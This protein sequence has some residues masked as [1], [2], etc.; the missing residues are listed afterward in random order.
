MFGSITRFELNYQLR[1][2]AFIAIF[3]IFFLL[4]FFATVSD[5]VS[6]GASNTVNANS[7]F[8]ITQ[9]IQIMSLFAMIIPTACLATTLLRDED[10]KT[11]EMFHATPVK[12]L[13]FV[14]GRF[15]GGLLVTLLAFASVPLGALIGPVFGK[16]VGWLQP[17]DLGP[18]NIGH[19]VQIFL[20]MGVPNMFITG[21]ILFS[22]ANFTR[23]MIMVFAALLSIYTLYFAGNAILSNP[24]LR[25][26]IALVDPFALNTYGFATQYWTPAERNTIVAP[27]EGVLLYNRLIWI[28]VGLALLAANF[29]FF[30]FRKPKAIRRKAAGAAEAG[31]TVQ[32]IVLPRVAPS[33]GASAQM[34]QFRQRIRFEM[35]VVVKNL[36][37]WVLL[38]LGL[39]NA[40]SSLLFTNSLYGTPPYPVT[41][42][43]ID[44]LVGSFAFVPI[45]VAVYYA[46]ELVWR[47]RNVRMSDIVDATPTPSWV[48]VASKFIAL[49][50]VI[51]ALFGVAMITALLVQLIKGFTAVDIGQYILRLFADFALPFAILAALAIFFQVVFNNKWLGIMAMIVYTIVTLIAANYGFDHNLY[52]YGGSPTAPYSDMNGYGHYLG[53]SLWFN[54]YWGLIAAALI[55][56]CYLLWNRGAL[57]PIWRRFGQ[58]PARI[59]LA[60]GGILAASLVGAGVV[61]GYIFYNTN[62]LNTYRNQDANEDRAEAFELAYRDHEF[63]PIPRITAVESEVDIYPRQRRYTIDGK[64]TLINATDAPIERVMID[65][66]YT[67]DVEAQ[68]IEGATL[69]ESDDDYNVYWFEFDEPLAPGATT[70]MTFKTGRHDRGFRNS[71]NVS[72]INYNGTFFNNGEAFP[73]I[74]FNAGKLL[75]NPQERRKRGLEELPR[76]YKLEDERFFNVS[77]LR[78]DSLWVDFATTVSTSADQIA[79][80]PGYLEREWEENGRRYFRYVMDE[81][82]QN[83]YSFQ[84]GDYVVAEG[85][86]EDVQLQVFYHEDHEFNVDRMIEGMAD[87]LEYFS[88]HFSP[89]QYRQ[90]R[91]QEFP[92]YQSFAQSF[93]NTVPYSEGIGFI[94][95]VRDPDDI[96]FIYYVTAHEVAHQWWGHQV[97]PAPV[98]GAAMVTETLAQ[99]SA[100][101]VLEKEY[102]AEH[103]RRFLKF[104]LDSYLR[105]RAA[106]NR[107]EL[108]LF[109]EE[110]QGYIHYRK[111]SIAMWLLQDIIGEDKVNRALNRLADEFGY[112]SEPF[113]RSVDLI[114]V[115]REEAGP[116]H[117][118]L[119]TDLF[120]K[121]VLYDLRVED[122][123][124]NER[125]DGRW[126]VAM[127]VFARKLEADGQGEETEIALDNLPVDVGVFST[128]LENVNSGT[129]H[130]LAFE[131]RPLDASNFV[132]EFVVDERPSHA[133]VDPYNKVIDRITNDNL[134][135]VRY[136]A[137]L[138]DAEGGGEPLASAAP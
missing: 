44:A 138:N 31:D 126:D 123:V 72:T 102:G 118:A 71:G 16:A 53:I 90:M 91:I 26:F 88:E 25:E 41:R 12:P 85:Q 129:D 98:Q 20:V 116:E 45:V 9:I 92:A 47:E 95:D 3:A 49:S 23:S 130:I 63:D 99:Y 66:S 75:Q 108:P 86:W 82:I 51:V 1:G 27:L 48:F 97:S 77:G 80:A 10:F 55:V 84:S 67:A 125:D 36:A 33:F 128:N 59:G 83:F 79:I 132:V 56:V 40:L 60:S 76:I 43:M 58:L 57:S 112:R 87:S 81:P 136:D 107:E 30:S 137:A 127:R 65:Y 4:V 111:G 105:G 106:E 74:G 115:L 13:I 117:D 64:Y 14:A 6:I 93:P 2:P 39:V 21:M 122:A 133:G 15:T 50:F 134:K 94:G 103:M 24:D 38:L 62:V 11:G 52:L 22:V 96:D 7:P 54:L 61:G 110:N 109:K 120:E 100:L 101:K 37:F 5:Q 89:F 19:Y 104:E 70:R 68:S 119:I 18:T 121:I 73:G 34:A 42:L 78:P 8:A 124:A 114:R 131:K 32:Q 17:E 113:T 29:A 135:R 69:V 46:G 35:G 28:G